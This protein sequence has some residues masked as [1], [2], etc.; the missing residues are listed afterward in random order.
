MVHTGGVNRIRCMPQNPGII[1][2]MAETSHV[3]IYDATAVFQVTFAGV[4]LPQRIY[5]DF[6]AY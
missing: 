2:T 3:Y 1:A 6:L 5:F 4:I